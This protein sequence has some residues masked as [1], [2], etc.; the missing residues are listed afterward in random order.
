MDHPCGWQAQWTATGHGYASEFDGDDLFF[1]LVSGLEVEL[2]MKKKPRTRKPG[3][4]LPLVK[5]SGNIS[6]NHLRLWNIQMTGSKA[7]DTLTC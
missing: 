2:G 4:R 1:G 6:P 7:G 3:N 5:P